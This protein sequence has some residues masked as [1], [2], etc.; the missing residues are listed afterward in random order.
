MKAKLERR[1]R[2]KKRHKAHK[3]GSSRSLKK[4]GSSKRSLH[5]QGS[6][7]RGLKGSASQPVLGHSGKLAPLKR[8]GSSNRSMKL[9]PLS[10]PPS[11]QQLL[12]SQPVSKP[13]ASPHKPS[14]DAWTA[15]SSVRTVLTASSLKVAPLLSPGHNKASRSWR[16]LD[17]VEEP[18]P[19]SMPANKRAAPPPTLHIHDDPSLAHTGKHV[20]NSVLSSFD[21]A[22][23]DKA[24]TPLANALAATRRTMMPLGTRPGLATMR[25][26]ARRDSDNSLDTGAHPRPSRGWGMRTRRMPEQPRLV[27]VGSQPRN[28][29]ELAALVKQDSRGQLMPGRASGGASGAGAGAG[30]RSFSIDSAA[31]VAQ[32]TKADRTRELLRHRKSMVRTSSKRTQGSVDSFGSVTRVS[33]N[34]VDDSSLSVTP[35]PVKSNRSIGFGAVQQ[36]HDYGGGGGGGDDDG[37]WVGTV[38]ES[39][40]PPSSFGVEPLATDVSPKRRGSLVMKGGP[41]SAATPSHHLI[42][43]V[44]REESGRKLL[45]EHDDED[46]DAF[47]AKQQ[48]TPIK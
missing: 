36:H 31:G 18:D 43:I 37:M 28:N 45:D 6:S 42:G 7:K 11:M 44:V 30:G 22:P 1:K 16:Q 13:A 29:A 23:S 17:R 10:R 25:R 2:R 38:L 32:R 9:P 33:D 46:L 27:R 24:S 47:R 3:H 8:A 40:H 39:H 20:L 19:I 15:H 26:Q 14:T 21:G 4:Q 48:V 34:D 41:H 5:K 35:S 12:A